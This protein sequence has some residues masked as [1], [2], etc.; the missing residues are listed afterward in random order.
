[1]K[2]LLFTTLLFV[3]LF[4]DVKSQNSGKIIKKD[5]EIASKS[6]QY[7]LFPIGKEGLIIYSLKDDNTS[8]DESL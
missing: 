5:I 7:H 6:N 1:M 4:N 2:N 8:T 3:F